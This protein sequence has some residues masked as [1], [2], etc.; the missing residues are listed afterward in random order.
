MGSN[1]KALKEKPDIYNRTKC[2][3]NEEIKINFL[4]DDVIVRII[5]TK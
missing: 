2:Y 4:D 3:N 1:Q 5:C